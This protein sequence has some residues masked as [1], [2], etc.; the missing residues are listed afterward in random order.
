TKEKFTPIAAMLRLRNHLRR[1]PFSTGTA[2]VHTPPSSSSRTT[3]SPPA[4]SHQRK[5][6]RP[7]NSSSPVS[8]RPPM[9]T[10]SA[11][12]SPT[13]ASRKPTSPRRL[14][15]TLG[16]SAPAWTKPYPHASPGSGNGLSPPQI[17]RLITIVQGIFLN[18][19]G[20]S[21]LEFY[22]S[23]LGSYDKQCGLSAC[24]IAWLYLCTGKLLTNN[25]EHL[26]EMVA[27]AEKL[28]VHRSSGMFKSA[29]VT[30]CN[31]TPEMTRAKIESLE[32]ALGYCEVKLAVSKLPRILTLSEVTMG[33]KVE[34]L[35]TEFG[36]EPSYIARRPSIL[37]CSLE[38]RL[39]PR[40]YVIYVLKEKGLVKRDIDLFGVFCMSHKKFVETY[41]DRQ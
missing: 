27:R 8:S 36:L 29:L 16:S 18:P 14:P 12:S 23:L 28:G 9:P 3:S 5:P 10:P 21:R 34:F 37:T 13:P 1:L 22:I 6:S 4:A 19:A 38:R 35:R 7:R 2:F 32:R 39:I 25:L 17:S 41:L 20:I 15:W 33:H 11:H 26:K 31:L 24:D 40:H 30:V